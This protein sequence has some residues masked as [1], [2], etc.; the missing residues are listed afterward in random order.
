MKARVLLSLLACGVWGCHSQQAP[1]ASA[2]DSGIFEVV[3]TSA[4]R[5]AGTPVGSFRTIPAADDNRVIRV[6]VGDLVT[7]SGARFAPGDADDELK[8]EVEWGDGQRSATGCGPCRVEHVYAVGRHEL[9]ATVHD[10][11]LVDRGSVTQEFTVLVSGPG[12]PELPPAPSPST[13]CHSIAA[14]TG[15]CPTGATQFCLAPGTTVTANNPAHAQSACNT[16][17]GAGVCAQVTLSCFP[18]GGSVR[19]WRNIAGGTYFVYGV[20]SGT[21][22]APGDIL[23]G[24]NAPCPA[25]TRWA[26]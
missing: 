16:C 14:A 13:N 26:P 11:R 1:V 20:L 8:L 7:I 3:H 6:F 22:W 4:V 10:R 23:T 19:T 15:A 18:P 2:P 5:A 17:F 25:I 21:G 9:V 12:E 24:A